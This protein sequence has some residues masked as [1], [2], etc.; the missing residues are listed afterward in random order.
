MKEWRDVVTHLTTEFLRPL[1]YETTLIDWWKHFEQLVQWHICAQVTL[2][3]MAAEQNITLPELPQPST[4]VV[5]NPRKELQRMYAQSLCLFDELDEYFKQ[6]NVVLCVCSD[7]M[8]GFYD[9]HKSAIDNAVRHEWYI[10]AALRIFSDDERREFTARHEIEVDVKAK[11]KLYTL[12]F[13]Q[14]FLLL[15]KPR[16]PS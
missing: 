2:H 8:R 3:T 10:G 4:S 6:Q 11:V 1:G 5:S 12:R 9:I 14:K 7:N 15:H 16:M 13:V